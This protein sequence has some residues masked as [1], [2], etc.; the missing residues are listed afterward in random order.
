MSTTIKAYGTEA[1]NDDLKP[2]DIIRR[3][4]GEEDVKIDITYCGVCHS[5]IHT[6]RNEWGNS[7]YPV[8]PGHEIIGR[9]IEI[10]ANVSEFK[11]GQLVGVGCLVD[12]CQTCDSCKDHLEQYCEN[13]WTGT[14]NSRDRH[15]T[16]QRTYG[17][18]STSIVVNKKFILHIPENLDEKSVA[19]LLCA[20]ITTWSPLK[21]WNV[22]KGDKIGVV[23]LGGLGH[24]GVKFANALGAHVVMI[25]SSSK[26]ANDA[27][28]LGAHEVLISK[29][30]DEMQK[31]MNTFDFILNTIPVGHDINPY[32]ALLKRDA[33]M[34][35]VGAVE[36]LKS[37][38]GGG[39]IM[40]RK[41]IAGSLIGGIKETQ[42]ML[43]FC[44]KHNIVSDIE[45]IDMKD[46]NR[47]YQRMI[48]S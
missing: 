26:K 39:I 13:G 19:P 15:I 6:A 8:V 16:G 45:L 18:Y 21:H 31:H 24:M 41:K 4:V 9:V 10:G 12:S 36:P 7:V 17:G 14:Y 35:I 2:L 32:I 1:A 29:N 27:K 20:G 47:A 46:I 42:E 23:G 38:H 43:D 30:E 48:G 37:F 34:V 25:T 28:S 5:D 11:P 33:T 44:G 3:D 40:G 22:Q